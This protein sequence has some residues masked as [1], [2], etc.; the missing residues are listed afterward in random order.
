[1]PRFVRQRATTSRATAHALSVSE[2]E[3][4]RRARAVYRRGPRLVAGQAGGEPRC[5][6][7]YGTVAGPQQAER[8]LCARAKLS[9]SPEAI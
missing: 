4:P 8:A 6:G 3:P 1:M 9:F 5:L 2:S 7:L